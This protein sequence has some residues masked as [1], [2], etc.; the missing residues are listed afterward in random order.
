MRYSG[1]ATKVES[2]TT[3]LLHLEPV[4]EE[5]L[6]PFCFVLFFFFLIQMLFLLSSVWASTGAGMHPG[7]LMPLARVF[8]HNLTHS[9]EGSMQCMSLSTPMLADTSLH[10]PYSNIYIP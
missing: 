4:T 3:Q 5:L 2:H 7:R 1:D 9:W 10:M 6:P 8:G